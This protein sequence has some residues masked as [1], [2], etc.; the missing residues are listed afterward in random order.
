[1]LYNMKNGRTIE[2]SLDEFLRLSD[3]EL[4]RMEGLNLGEAIENPFFSSI[5]GN[6]EN[7]LP[8]SSEI[9][10]TS[11][12]YNIKLSDRDLVMEE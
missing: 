12:P 3:A 7:D 8:D 10:L 1:M 9:P 6:T 11:L 2:L 5:I 4:E